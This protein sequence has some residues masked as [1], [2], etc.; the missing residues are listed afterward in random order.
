MKAKSHYRIFESPEV[1]PIPRF[2]KAIVID[3]N[4]VD[5]KITETILQAC[6]VA[7]EVSIESDPHKVIHN[8][9][10]V[11]RLTDVP[12]L[13]F[14]NLHMKKLDNLDFLEEFESM[15]DFVKNKCKLIILTSL[16]DLNEKHRALMKPSVVRYL[17]KPLDLFQLREFI[18]Q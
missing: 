7:E 1:A 10:N 6:N 16:N 18:T 8:L 11:E 17:I 3:D 5:Q 15:S 14:V 13:I 12:E 9:H 2:R 4:E